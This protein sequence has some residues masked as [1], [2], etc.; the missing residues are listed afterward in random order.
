MTDEFADEIIIMTLL[1]WVKK[2]RRGDCTREQKRAVYEALQTV[3]QSY[4]TP[5]E[6]ADFFGK[7]KDA[8][9]S[10][11]KRRYIGK[12]RRNTV[13]YSFSQFSRIVPD[14]WHKKNDK[15]SK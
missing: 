5:D 4:A 15:S 9:Y 6:L 11:I 14:S 2:L 12:P 10:V 3:G 1:F 13:M 7:S 8:V